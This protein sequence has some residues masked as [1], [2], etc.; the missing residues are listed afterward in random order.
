V[1]G[2][3]DWWGWAQ[4]HSALAKYVNAKVFRTFDKIRTLGLKGYIQTRLKGERA[5]VAIARL[6]AEQQE[7]DLARYDRFLLI[8]P[9]TTREMLQ[10]HWPVSGKHL[11]AIRDLTTAKNI[12]FVI[13]SY[14]YGVTVGPDQWAEGRTFWGFEKGK[15]Y[16][17]SLARGQ[18]A[19]FGATEKIPVIDTFPSF[20]AAK[21][22][23][24]F[25]DGDGHFTPAGHRAVAAHTLQ[26]QQLLTLIQSQLTPAPSPESVDVTPLSPDGSNPNS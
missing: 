26:D 23:K 25:Y 4:R 7:A 17:G 24:L 1:D 6:K 3:F 2:K 15:M 12:L 22:D 10:R 19:L 11:T 8:R 5:K 14:P 9:T 20:E 13:G 21:S 16:D 18:F